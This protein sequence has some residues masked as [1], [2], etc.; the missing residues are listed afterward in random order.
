MGIHIKEYNFSKGHL[1]IVL[2][3][4]SPRYLKGVIQ[5]I[6]MCAALSTVESLQLNSPISVRAQIRIQH[7]YLYA[8]KDDRQQVPYVTLLLFLVLCFSC[9]H[10]F[11]IYFIFSCLYLSL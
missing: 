7:A 9:F 6:I 8:E 4:Q 2:R 10:L 5:L 11:I 3:L 1:E